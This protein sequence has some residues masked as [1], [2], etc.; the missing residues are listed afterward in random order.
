VCV[1]NNVEKYAFGKLA[2]VVLEV[3]LLTS[4]FR[5]PF[6]YVLGF[7]RNPRFTC[8]YAFRFLT[9]FFLFFRGF[10]RVFRTRIGIILI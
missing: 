3:F 7:V 10:F 6:L 1:Q 5:L 8:T 2:R 9:S 4:P